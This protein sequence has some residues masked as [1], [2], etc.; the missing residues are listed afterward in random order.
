MVVQH[1][2]KVFDFSIFLLYKY[3][4]DV[5]GMKIIIFSFF[6]VEVIVKMSM[7]SF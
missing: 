1:I 6:L 5:L 2:I 7:C 4:L 3:A